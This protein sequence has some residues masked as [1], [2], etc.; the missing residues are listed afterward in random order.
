M[1]QQLTAPA[2]LDDFNEDPQRA[3]LLTR[4]AAKAVRVAPRGNRT[5]TAKERAEQLADQ[6]TFVAFAPA[7]SREP[8]V[9]AGVL[10]GWATVNRRPVVIISHDAAVAAGAIGAVFADAV[11][12]AQRFAIDHG[13]PIIY[14]N[15][16]SGARIH[17][18]IHAL[19]GCGGIFRLNVKATRR[20]P[21]IS[22]ILGPCAGAA[23]YSPALT[24]WTIMVREQGQM[25][26]T[27][28]DIVKAATGEDATA[29]AIGGADMHT[30]TSGVAHLAVDSE[31]EAIQAT[32]KILSFTPTYAGG[33]LP[34]SLPVGPDAAAAAELPYVVPSKASVGF[35][36][37]QVIAGV[38]DEGSMFEIMPTRSP[39]VLTMFARLDGKPVGILANQPNARGGILDTQTSVKASRFVDYCG[40]FGI[41]V[42][43]FVDVPGFL[44][45]TVEEG[46]GVITYGATLLRAYAEATG[47]L[48]TVIVRKA[49]GGAYIAM[50]SPSLG[51]DA[52]WAWP[53]S[54]I[55]VMGPGGAVAL[56][57]RRE[58]AAAEDPAALRDSLAADYRE[59]V[60]RPWIAAEA[61]IVDDVI[62]PEETRDRLVASLRMLTA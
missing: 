39:S 48:L 51:A 58:L 43:T 15:D 7:R 22:V 31:A 11:Q 36:M 26:L 5:F 33:P 56:L 37:T 52:C 42:L 44:P 35:D 59:N 25:F 62:L 46:R 21:Q 41:P 8:G 1:T 12:D 27:G 23:A 32:R 47:P 4:R 28:P 54:E 10:T 34:E 38:V 55:A 20:V 9:G 3:A 30:Q 53:G 45:G 13:Y 57:N 49:Y 18:G 17:D 61:G 50:G 6:G 40:R 60:A 14:L 2:D 29:E 24:D 19:H 16:S